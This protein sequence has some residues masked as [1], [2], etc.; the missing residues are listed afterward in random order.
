MTWNAASAT[1]VSG[2]QIVAAIPIPTRFLARN[3]LIFPM[4]VNNNAAVVGNLTIASNGATT[5]Y[6]GQGTSGFNNSGTVGI[7]G[8]SVSWN[9]V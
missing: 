8:G 4:I 5:F 9:I 3:A 6:T 2:T 1:A 7:Y